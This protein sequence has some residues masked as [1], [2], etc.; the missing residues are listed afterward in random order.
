MRRIRRTGHRCRRGCARSLRRIRDVVAAF[1]IPIYEIDG[2]EA[3][4]L[5]GTLS[6]QA[7]AKHVRTVIAT[8]D[9][10]TLQL[11]DDWIR[12]TFARSP[13]QGEFEYFDRA[14]VEARYGVRASAGRRL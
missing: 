1:N 7:E 6:R 3:D 14:A 8:G 5:L 11:V 12:V 13:R 10:D 9:L 2:F 4:D